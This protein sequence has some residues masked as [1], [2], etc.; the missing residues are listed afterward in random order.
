MDENPLFSDKAAK[1]ALMMGEFYPDF[2]GENPKIPGAEA[3]GMK[4][5]EELF[6]SA[7]R[8]H[9]QQSSDASSV[10]MHRKFRFV[11]PP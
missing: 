3:P 6:L 2:T 11:P 10:D 5:R 8:G 1:Y 4:G 7:Q 9:G